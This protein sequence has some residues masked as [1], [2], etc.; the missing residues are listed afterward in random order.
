MKH[1]KFEPGDHIGCEV[2][3]AKAVDIHHIIPRGMGGS[4]TKDYIENLVSLCRT[5][6]IHA[7]NSKD[8]N[9][10]VKN[11]HLKNLLDGNNI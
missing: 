5:C 2:C 8:F 10:L 9:K 6:H 4:N 3:D 7:E 1:F 11:I